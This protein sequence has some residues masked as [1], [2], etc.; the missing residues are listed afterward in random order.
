MTNKIRVVD[1]ICGAGKTTWVFDYIRQ[2]PEHKWIFVSPYLD[3]AG[4]GENKGRI[5]KE[6]PGYK[7]VSPTSAPSKTKDF[8]R[9]A[10]KGR[11]IAITHKL[12]T[13]F[14]AEI[15]ALLKEKEYHLIIDETIDLVSFYEDISHE[16][17]KFLILAGMVKCED[18][19]NL[20]WNNDLWPNY[21]GRDWRIKEL[22]ELGCLWLYGED[23]L[24]QR[25]PP[26]CMKACQSV[27]I[28]T[29][30]FE[31]SLMHCWMQLNDLEWEY[32]APESMRK[33]AEIKSI[34]RDRIVLVEP[35]KLIRDL[36]RT[37]YGVRKSNVFNKGWYDKTAKP[38]DLE[39]IKKSIEKTLKDEMGKG[40]V[41]WTTFKD[42]E[43][44]L[45][46][47]GYT[48]AK[49]ITDDEGNK[50]LRKPF[51]A[52]NMRASNEY[53]DCVNCIYTINIY[54][55]GSL[56]SHLAQHQVHLD[57]DS[58]ALSE[59]IQFIFRGCI[60]EH[61]TMHLYILSDRMRDLVS[62]WLKEDY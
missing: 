54:P 35:P 30:M 39:R 42:Y 50:K 28:L 33:T 62:N 60:R 29:Y 46:G 49:K 27:V 59:I 37:E 20:V 44:D 55:H 7:F 23:V 48:R 14:S 40:N 51:V 16:D 47:I 56:S 34:I 32:Y 21:K 9:L 10:Q 8:L 26:T 36:Q 1:A 6:L 2:H 17:V 52:K 24:I 19:G 25:I 53:R 31:A 13:G 22:C 43:A 41:F 45:A 12:F 4:D 61:K 15:A 5:Q 18:R 11:N 57:E 3:E 58:Y 38:A